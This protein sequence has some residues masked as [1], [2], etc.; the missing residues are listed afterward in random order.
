MWQDRTPLSLPQAPRSGYGA[1]RRYPQG[2]QEAEGV[3]CQRTLR[4]KMLKLPRPKAFTWEVHEYLQITEIGK[5]EFIDRVNAIEWNELLELWPNQDAMATVFT[6]TLQDILYS[7]FKWK[8]VRRKSTDKPWI[9][10]ALRVR[11][12]IRLAVFR[13]EGRSEHWKRLDKGIKA[14][15][16]F[17]KRQDE[18]NMAK[19][20]ENSGRTGQWYSIYKYIAS[21]DMP[22]R[23]NITDLDPNQ[24]PLDLSNLLAKHFSSV[25]NQADRLKDSDIPDSLVND[26]LIPQMDTARVEK[27]LKSFKKCNSRVQGDIPRELGNPCSKKLAE[28]LTQI[29]NASFLNKSWPNIWKVETIIPISKTASPGSFDDIRPISMTTL[30]SKL[31]E[32]L[33][34]SFTLEETAGNWKTHQYGG[35]KG[36]ST[37]HVLVG[38]W[39]KILTG[40]DANSKAVVVS[41]ID[42]SK[43][44]SRCSFQEILI[45]YQ[46]LGQSNWGIKTH[47]AFL[48]NRRM[49]VKVGNILSHEQ[50]VT[51]GAVQGSILGVMDH[52]AVLEDINDDI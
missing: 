44:F 30:W 19:K 26:G 50:E 31:M 36:S 28:A 11:F 25:T 46:K 3:Q 16:A 7:C 40:L 33:V 29:Y 4:R 5:K 35:K 38:L 51:G 1:I 2:E 37:D 49:R 14:T 24:H 21:D 18:E 22:S 20:L 15:I 41:A 12:R 39:N 23:W 17:R 10:D 52:N 9:S 32:L 48:T 34:A 42:F 43:S 6:E 45:S 8:R 47:A 27:L 13:D